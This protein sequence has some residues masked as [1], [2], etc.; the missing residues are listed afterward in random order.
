MVGLR[1]SV[2][3]CAV[4]LAVVCVVIEHIVGFLNMIAASR[5]LISRERYE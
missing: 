1:E 2:G 3:G 4:V 5:Y